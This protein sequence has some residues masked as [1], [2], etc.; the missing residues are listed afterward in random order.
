MG[1]YIKVLLFLTFIALWL[2]F[3]VGPSRTLVEKLAAW[4]RRFVKKWGAC[5]LCGNTNPKELRTFGGARVCLPC[6]RAYYI[7]SLAKEA[8]EQEE[9]A[10][11]KD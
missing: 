1:N 10:G 2:Y 5:T 8:K 7:S 3:V 11:G 4:L 9:K 6:M